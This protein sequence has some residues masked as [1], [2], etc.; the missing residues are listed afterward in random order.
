MR[1][2]KKEKQK[3]NKNPVERRLLELLPQG[4]A[5]PIGL[6]LVPQLVL[7]DDVVFVA[8]VW[9]VSLINRLSPLSPFR[10]GKTGLHHGLRPARFLCCH[11]ELPVSNAA[12]MGGVGDFCAAKF[13]HY[14]QR[15][16]LATTVPSLPLVMPNCFPA[17][18]LFA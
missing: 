1:K 3:K 13:Q 6:D 18:S 15:P 8:V 9:L 14:H 2:K 7:T 12:V 16:A 17:S 5:R 10:I 11:A 4:P